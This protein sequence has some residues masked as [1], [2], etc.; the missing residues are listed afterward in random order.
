MGLVIFNNRSSK[1]YYAEIESPP[2]YKTPARDYE[3]THVPGRNGDLLYDQGSYQN[4]DVT[5]TMSVVPPEGY[6]YA[7]T[8]LK[9]QSWL[10][11]GSGY[12][13]LED[14]YD[15]EHYRLAC[16]KDES[17]IDN[18]FEKAGRVNVTFH[19][20]PGR[21]LKDGEEPIL[22]DEATK[23]I[24]NKTE[25]NARPFFMIAGSGTGEFTVNNYTV[26]I[27][28]IENG[29]IIDCDLM[30]CYKD[31]TNLNNRVS[32]SPVDDFPVFIPGRN[33]MTFSGGIEALVIIPRWWSL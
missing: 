33:V 6:T 4:L 30:D 21:F 10:H 8:M 24:I 13:R 25:Q 20:K 2:W 17:E 32:I 31:N 18:Y 27:S 19:C 28:E 5:Y 3:L 9:F 7:E 1:D 26:T 16:F 14:S 15:P 29:M 22:M 23:V 11:S 12:C